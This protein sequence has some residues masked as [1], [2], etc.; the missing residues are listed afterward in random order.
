MTSLPIGPQDASL[1]MQAIT[2]DP[3]E[4]EGEQ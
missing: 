3:D 4:L 2:R 1:I